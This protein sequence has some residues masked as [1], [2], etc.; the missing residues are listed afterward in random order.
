MA[1]TFNAIVLKGLNVPL[2]L[3]EKDIPAPDAGSIII[4]ALASNIAPYL[5]EIYNGQRQYPLVF[6]FTPGASCIGRVHTIG[7]DTTA[8]AEGQLVLCDPTI[9]ARDDPSTQILIGTHAGITPGSTKLASGPWRNGSMAEYVKMPLENVFPLDESALCSREGYSIEQLPFLQTLMIPYGGLDDAGVKVGDTV[10]VAPATGKFGGAAVLAALSMGATV[11]ACGRNE[12]SL[13]ALA[14]GMASTSLKT[15]AWT[16][17]VSR[18]VAGLKTLAG[19]KGADVY[20]DFSPPEAGQNGETPAH[21]S[22]CLSVL[23]RG[24]TCTLMGGLTG[25]VS[26]P[27]QLLLFNNLVVRGKF[28]YER[29]QAEQVIKMAEAG[30][31]KLGKA[32]GLEILG[33][34]GLS[35][36]DEAL[37][38]AAEHP[39]WGQDV[40]LVP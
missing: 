3:E 17:D 23:K 31:L 11:I 6:P 30:K 32:V 29:H 13:A 9:R 33:P 5:K 14:T 12:K 10:I 8:F 34:F 26:I 22:A 24:G 39:G 35:Q 38:V 37:Q 25:N 40:V 2:E 15:M 7:P 27:H 16:G 1:N 21:L 20:I 4:K 18:D 19:A 28:M 36:I